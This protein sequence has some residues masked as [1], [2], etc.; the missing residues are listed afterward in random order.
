MEEEAEAQVVL[1]EELEVVMSKNTPAVVVDSPSKPK[2]ST[3]AIVAPIPIR[4]PLA[5]QNKSLPRTS[6]HHTRR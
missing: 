5:S 1:E 6:P 2:S 4:A 3:T